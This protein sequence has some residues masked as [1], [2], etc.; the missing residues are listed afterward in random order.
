MT[1]A[2]QRVQR[3]QR[4][5]EQ[6]AQRAEQALRFATERTRQL[7]DHMPPELDR[8]PLDGC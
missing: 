2:R 6:A 5:A 7:P 1:D 4:E 8:R 3:A